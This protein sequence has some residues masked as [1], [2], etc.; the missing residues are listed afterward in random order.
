MC[1][2]YF[3]PVYDLPFHFLNQ[4]FQK[5]NTFDFDDVRLIKFFSYDSCLLTRELKWYNRKYLV[6]TKEGSNSN[7]RTTKKKENI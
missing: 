5:V 6:N 3:L 2:K 7:R 4:V 1:C